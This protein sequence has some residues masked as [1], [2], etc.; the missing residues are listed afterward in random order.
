MKKKEI[1]IA[2]L[3]LVVPAF[4]F[5]LPFNDDMVDSQIKTGQVMRP[6]PE[7]AVSVGSL[8]FYSETK[9]EA[10]AFENPIAM[11]KV[12]TMIGKRLF[13]TNCGACHGAIKPDGDS[14]YRP[15]PV[16]KFV[17]GP[18]LGMEMYHQSDKPGQG[19]TDGQLFSVIRYGN[20]LMP[21]VGYKLAPNEMWH[22]INYVRSVQQ[23]KGE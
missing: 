3:L 1:A 2:V 6:K 8:E 10:A 14:G 22:I 13:E 9:E 11:S 7:G 16:A 18:N 19:R 20:V 15:A 17:P 12:S 5:A 23:S 4:V 21:A